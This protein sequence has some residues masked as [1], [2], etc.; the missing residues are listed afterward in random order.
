MTT[1]TAKEWYRLFRA[2]FVQLLG[3][4]EDKGALSRIVIY[5][6]ESRA[7]RSL[8]DASESWLLMDRGSRARYLVNCLEDG[9][10]LFLY[11]PEDDRPHEVL[12]EE[13]ELTLSA[14]IEL[15]APDAPKKPGLFSRMLDGDASARFEEKTAAY[16][17]EVL[18]TEAAA[19][20]APIRRE[21]YDADRSYQ[22]NV[23]IPL[24]EKRV[25]E[26]EHDLCA[27]EID[28]LWNTL[29]AGRERYI[30]LFAPDVSEE[31]MPRNRAAAAAMGITLADKG[32]VLINYLVGEEPDE[33]EKADLIASAANA[34]KTAGEAFRAL[35][36]G[37]KEQAVEM[38]RQSIK[39]G[40][41]MWQGVRV[42]NSPSA[43]TIGMYLSDLLECVEED[44]EIE[45]CTLLER[46]DMVEARS[47]ACVAKCY[48]TFVSGCEELLTERYP[49]GTLQRTLLAMRA[50]IF[51]AAIIDLNGS[52]RAAYQIF[53]P[54]AL[55]MTTGKRRFFARGLDA[56]VN[57]YSRIAVATQILEEITT[58]EKGMMARNLMVLKTLDPAL[59]QP[60]TDLIPGAPVSPEQLHRVMET[61]VQEQN[62]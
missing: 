1:K 2:L 42:F 20:Y 45:N 57:Q 36:Q 31:I 19:E 23:Y 41:G 38:I 26:A 35:E 37:D 29:F 39:L 3:D 16:E 40:V 51:A 55:E 5:D 60:R 11:A 22:Q 47:A 48:R 21:Q 46:I 9:D 61:N 33:E 52:G 53:D 27:H 32:M 43:L 50:V 44:P 12:W 18:L 24:A 49:A 13:D 56:V 34:R 25:L 4:P 30:E 54:V 10:R 17:K 59:M 62:L 7:L 14:P 58:A 8:A 28:I 6:P 15:S